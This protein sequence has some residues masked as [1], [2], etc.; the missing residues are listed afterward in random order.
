[1]STFTDAVTDDGDSSDSDSAEMLPAVADA[2]SVVTKPHE[3]ARDW[4]RRHD[5]PVVA[6][7]STYVPRE[8]LWASGVLPV[9][10]FGSRRPED[11]TVGDEH[12]NRRLFCPF[13]RDVLAQGLLG[14]Y[15]YTDGIVLASVCL[16]LRQTFDAW[17]QEVAREEDFT[18]YIAMPHGTPAE[19]G[20][21]FLPVKRHGVDYASAPD[22]GTCPHAPAAYLTT[23]FDRLR[24]ELES[25]TGAPLTDDD[26]E[27]AIDVYD[28]SRKLLRDIYAYRAESEPRLSGTDATALVTAGQ[29]MDPH[30]YVDVLE[31]ALAQL[32]DGAGA[33]SPVDARLMVV[34]AVGDDR[35]LYRTV[36]RELEY[37]ATIVVE[38]SSVG[39]TDFYRPVSEPSRGPPAK[40][41]DPLKAIARRYL[42]RPPYP[43]KQWDNRREHLRSLVSEYDVDGVLIVLE[44]R[45]D[46]HLRDIPHETNL[47]EEELDVPTLTVVAEKGRVPPGQLKTRVEAF[48][49]EITTPSMEGLY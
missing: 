20:D 36:E 49:E 26:L 9:R 48:V 17:V 30:E 22:G 18:H 2:L 21:E 31:S 28:R 4:K 15:D 47:F 27:A 1:M 40:D 8:I 3:Y 38:D 6:Y 19:T 5:A 7:L 24:A 44:E 12:H 37:D 16:H 41:D 33:P 25:F 29:L 14:R 35:T 10:A 11:V 23:K 32:E 42:D 13:S 34:T 45:C 39:T 46:I 43:S